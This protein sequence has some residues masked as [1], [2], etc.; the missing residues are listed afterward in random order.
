MVTI[1]ILG[2]LR[3]RRRL[4]S[5]SAQDDKMETV[6]GGTPCDGMVTIGILGIL[7]L[8]RRLRSD[9]AQDDKGETVSGGLPVTAWSQSA[10][11]G[12]FDCVV[13]FAPTPLRM[14]REREL[15]E[16]AFS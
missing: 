9:S 4:R 16:E 5:D 14:T 3:L 6:S 1:G 12:S 13:A 8:R 10:S 2:I 15:P 11:S 7:R